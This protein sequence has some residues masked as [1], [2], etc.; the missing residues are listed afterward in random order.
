MI[1]QSIASPFASGLVMPGSTRA[2]PH[3]GVLV[4]ALADRQPQAPQRDVIGH[5]GRAHRAEEDRV[6]RLEPVEA[7]L[8]DVVAVLEVVV[9]APRES[10]RP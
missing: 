4:E 5:V 8:G 9:A 6:E 1:T 7:A 3:V 2:G 10:A